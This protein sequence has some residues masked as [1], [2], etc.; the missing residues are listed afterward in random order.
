MRNGNLLELHIAFQITCIIEISRYGSQFKLGHIPVQSGSSCPVFIELIGSSA[1]HQRLVKP[2]VAGLQRD[3][4]VGS[5]SYLRS[6]Q[7]GQELHGFLIEICHEQPV[8]PFVV[9]AVTGITDSGKVQTVR[10]FPGH[11]PDKRTCIVVLKHIQPVDEVILLVCAVGIGLG[12][13]HHRAF[14]PDVDGNGAQPVLSGRSVGRFFVAGGGRNRGQHSQNDCNSFHL[15]LLLILCRRLSC[16]RIH[17]QIP[18]GNGA[19]RPVGNGNR[20]LSRVFLLIEV[21]VC[22]AQILDG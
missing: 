7:T 3:D 1:A 20:E 19:F 22:R 5:A 8:P 13:E 14:H 4:V 15:F 18:V 16:V 21:G 6:I 11:V 10:V 2:E 9:L 17:A 12:R